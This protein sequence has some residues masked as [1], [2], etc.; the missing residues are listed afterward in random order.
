M[1]EELIFRVL[2]LIFCCCVV[3]R[4]YKSILHKE[5]IPKNQPIL[6]IIFEFGVMFSDR[7]W[8]TDY[9]NQINK[10]KV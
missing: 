2:L 7:G 4:T 8:S 1:M 3:N 6:L 10:F 9:Q 5:R